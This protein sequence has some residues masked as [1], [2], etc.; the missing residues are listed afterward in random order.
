MEK[1]ITQTALGKNI[2]FFIRWTVISIVMGVL[3]GLVGS[4][5]GHGVAFAQKF[6]GEHDFMLYLMPVSGILIVIVHKLLRQVGNKGTNVI[7][8][9]IHSSEKIRFTMLPTIFISTILS[10][11]VG[12]SAGKEGAALQIGASI[13]NLLGDALKL[14]EK[15]KKIIIMCGMSGCFGAIFGTPL[16]AAMFGMEVAVIGV[17]YYT[18]LIPCVFAAFIGAEVS[19]LLGLHAE[20]FTIL[21]VPEF[22]F[23]TLIFPILIGILGAVVSICFC[24]LLHEA[25]KIYHRKFHNLYVRILVASV[26]FIALTLIFG[27]D[28]CG[29][30]FNLVEEAMHGESRYEAFLLKMLFTAVAL[31]GG[32]KGGEIVPTLAIGATLGSAVG[33]IIGFEPS[34]CAAC[35]MLALFVGATNCP[36]AT[37]FL[38]FELFGFEA[39]PY[40]TVT[41][42][43]SFALSGYYGLYSSQKFT[44]AK[45]KTE[46][47]HARTHHTKGDPVHDAEH[48]THVS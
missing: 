29:A 26:L 37:L 27:R 14:N 6:F 44:H 15:D 42:A 30:G 11:F 23:N 47:S 2:H 18:A 31:G 10:H 12:A 5:F 33:N 22:Q 34:L 32:F 20:A 1:N 19:H 7:L 16:A 28:Y 38:G 45:V 41:V 40:F 46:F 35:G 36:T 25:H 8:E 24:E 43:L 48:G 17:A 3:C 13:A 39:M 9:S 4:A 21:N